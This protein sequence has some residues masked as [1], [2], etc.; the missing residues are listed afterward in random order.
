MMARSQQQHVGVRRMFAGPEQ[1]PNRRD[2]APNQASSSRIRLVSAS[3]RTGLSNRAQSSPVGGQPD[4]VEPNRTQS[5][6]SRTK[7]RPVEHRRRSPGPNRASSEAGQVT[8]EPNRGKLT[9]IGFKSE[10]NLRFRGR[11]Y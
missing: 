2:V 8:S 7:S 10:H 6:V 1:R 5:E 11:Q 9:Q 4:Q 3:R